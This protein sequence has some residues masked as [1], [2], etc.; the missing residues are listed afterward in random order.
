VKHRRLLLAVSLA[1]L[2]PAV[3]SAGDF[4]ALAMGQHYTTW[5]FIDAS[6]I[7]A[8]GGGWVRAWITSVVTGPGRTNFSFRTELK[9]E[10]FNCAKEQMGVVQDITYAD[11]GE[12][13]SSQKHDAE[14]GSDVIPGSWGSKELKFVCE[15]LI[16]R[17]ANKNWVNI[18][19]SPEEFADGAYKH[20]SENFC[21]P[22]RQRGC[23]VP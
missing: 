4:W 10:R 17:S 13:V 16:A 11:A 19:V 12:V 23:F 18:T 21:T 1:M 20:F 22:E 8:Q 9:E 7:R 15:G 3:C 2:W 6:S 14:S 5:D